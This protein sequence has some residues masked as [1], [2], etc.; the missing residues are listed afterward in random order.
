MFYKTI[1]FFF[2]AFRELKYH[3]YPP[4]STFFTKCLFFLNGIEFISLHSTGV[5][6]IHISRNGKFT[7]GKDLVLGNWMDCYVSGLKGKC[8]IEVRNG[9]KLNIGN[10]VGMTLSTI[11]CHDSIHIKDNVKIGIGVHIFDT[12]FHSQNPF[13]RASPKLDWENRKTKPIIIES[14]VFIG[15]FAII[16]KGV[17]IGENSI[18]G[19]GS[20]VTKDIPANVIAVG[21]PCVP[22]KTIDQNSYIDMNMIN[23]FNKF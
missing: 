9:A 1:V 18:I 14:N 21:N 2:K 16:L 15:A 17:V 22:I 10:S 19:A 23:T 11:I 7:A 8:K 6:F 20:V 13:F 4:I 3:Y 12:D 5:P